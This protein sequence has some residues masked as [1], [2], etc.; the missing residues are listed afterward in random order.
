MQMCIR[1]RYNAEWLEALGVTEL[2]TTT[3]GFYELLKR[4]KTED[5]NGN[6]EADEIPLSLIHI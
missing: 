4:F 3:E 2:P 6:G 5:P 1:D